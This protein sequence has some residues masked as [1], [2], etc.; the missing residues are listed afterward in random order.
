[1][2]F[3]CVLSVCPLCV[4]FCLRFQNFIGQFTKPPAAGSQNL[5]RL[6][7]Q[8]SVSVC[9]CLLMSFFCIVYVH[10]CQLLSVSVGFFQFLS[11]SDCFCLFLS[12]FVY[13]CQFLSV[14]VHFLQFLYISD[15]FLQFL[16]FSVPLEFLLVSLLLSITVLDVTVLSVV[17]VAVTVERVMTVVKKILVTVTEVTAE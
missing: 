1:M 9:F 10:F 17:V 4:T 7:Y 16:Y 3:C 8:L 11:A 12:V 2:S 5:P 6:S 14:Y 15:C 13:V